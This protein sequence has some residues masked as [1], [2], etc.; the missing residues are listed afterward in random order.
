M[1]R[2]LVLTLLIISASCAFAQHHKIHHVQVKDSVSPVTDVAVQNPR[3]GRHT[4]AS[5][6][7]VYVI[8]NMPVEETIAIDTKISVTASSSNH[9]VRIKV[10]Q[11]NGGLSYNL[12]SEDGTL[13]DENWWTGKTVNVPFSRYGEG[14]YF[15]NI[16]DTLGN[17]AR[18][19]IT[20]TLN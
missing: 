18:Y 3:E 12:I 8:K 2:I 16:F 15:L 6:K 7:Y 14:V 17:E 11:N 5:R 10:E 13:L 9:K 4:G 1:K 19:R 20:K